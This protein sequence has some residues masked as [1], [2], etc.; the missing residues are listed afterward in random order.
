MGLA[1]K[2]FQGV[3]ACGKDIIGTRAKKRCTFC[4]MQRDVIG[5]RLSSRKYQQARRISAR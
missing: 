1:R 4:A 5:Y 2:S 3:C